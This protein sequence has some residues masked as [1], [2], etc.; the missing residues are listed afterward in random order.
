[1]SDEQI[2]MPEMDT[3]LG[4]AGDRLAKAVEAVENAT[5]EKEAAQ[6]EVLDLMVDEGLDKL[7]LKGN[8]F[9][10]TVRHEHVDSHEKL[11]MSKSAEKETSDDGVY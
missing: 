4:Q 7:K 2:T 10:L 8:G 3:P 6:K 5:A 11:K 1:M 9:V